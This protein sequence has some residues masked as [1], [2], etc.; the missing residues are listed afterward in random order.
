MQRHELA[1]WLGDNHLPDEQFDELLRIAD[2]IEA[3]YPDPD[4]ADDRAA[5]LTIAHRLLIGDDAADLLAELAA[6]RQAARQAEARA[7]A[8]LRQA[9]TMLV[10]AERSESG[11]AREAG[12]D[13]MA[14]RGWLGKR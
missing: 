3:R 14:V 4:D 10:P 12:L 5:A 9:A 6:E 1:A 2:H 7:L 13:R 8:G 11:F